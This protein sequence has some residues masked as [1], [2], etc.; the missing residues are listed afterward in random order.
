M[1]L[2]EQ[3]QSII[4]LREATVENGVI[5]CLVER[6]AISEVDGITF[7]LINDSHHLLIASGSE[8][9]ETSIGFH[10]IN[11]GASENAVRFTE[12]VVTIT[13][14]TDSKTLLKL[15]GS[16]MVVAW[17]GA[18]SIGVF[19]AR[20]LKK[21]NLRQEIF[22]KAIWF[23]VH[24]VSMSLTWLLTIAGVAIIWIDVGTWKTST[25]S[26]LGIIA[27][28]LCFIQPL[29]AFFRP[30]PDD[31]ARPIFNFMHGS[32]GKLAHFL[33]GNLLLENFHSVN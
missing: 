14:V 1:F 32:V 15:H 3:N 20:F 18:T 31:E 25:H 27:T 24:Q 19:S 13:I 28:V 6:D 11:Q 12:S 2:I 4:R 21:F 5:H 29:T 17:V 23:V 7:D 8:A 26:V 10:N 30:A 22:G 9:E 33:A 16:F